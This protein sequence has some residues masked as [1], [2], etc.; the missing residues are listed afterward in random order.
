MLNDFTA[1]SKAMHRFPA[2]WL[3]AFTVSL[4][5]PECLRLIVEEGGYRLITTED[6]M[7]IDLARAY[8]A[9]KEAAEAIAN[10]EHRIPGGD[11]NA[12]LYALRMAAIVYL[13]GCL[14]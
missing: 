9:R 10:L 11:G 7:L 13:G 2:A 5:D 12:L 8:L 3:A 1:D 4:K 6:A 14:R